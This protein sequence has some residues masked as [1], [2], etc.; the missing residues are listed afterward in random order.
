MVVP[1]TAG[2]RLLVVVVAR[3]RRVRPPRRPWSVVQSS[4]PLSSY[5]APPLGAAWS[6]VCRPLAHVLTG[7]RA[8]TRLLAHFW[9]SCE[10][11]IVSSSSFAQGRSYE[12]L[13]PP[14]RAPLTPHHRCAEKNTP[15]NPTSF[16]V[17]GGR[18]FT[19]CAVC[20]S[21]LLRG[22]CFLPCRGRSAARRGQAAQCMTHVVYPHNALVPLPQTCTWHGQ[23][24][25]Q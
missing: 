18:P 24:K 14:T 22:A 20:Y 11:W 4:R 8:S 15:L 13:L 2:R 21:L 12:A 7:G 19:P 9:W 10:P 1:G 17:P 16:F 23:S 6:V 3:R 25:E 5:R